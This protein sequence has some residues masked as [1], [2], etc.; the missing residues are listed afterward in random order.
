MSPHMLN[1]IILQLHVSFPITHAFMKLGELFKRCRYSML[2][3]SSPTDGPGAANWAALADPCAGAATPKPELPSELLHVVTRAREKWNGL[4]QKE[5]DRSEMR[6]GFVLHE[7]WHSFVSCFI[8]CPGSL[9]VRCMLVS[10]AGKVRHAFIACFIICVCLC[11][12]LWGYPS[13][14]I[15]K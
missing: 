10:L 8:P 2:R 5:T 15:R 11:C 12:C 3:W 4:E 9:L 14:L 6:L 1:P 13:D 7:N